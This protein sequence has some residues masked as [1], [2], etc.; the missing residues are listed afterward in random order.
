[1]EVWIPNQAFCNLRV[2]FRK[3]GLHQEEAQARGMPFLKFHQDINVILCPKVI[4]RHRAEESQAIGISSKS[5]TPPVGGGS[6][7]HPVHALLSGIYTDKL[8]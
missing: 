6:P 8:I 7:Q 2:H 1:V 4:A 3:L 5:G